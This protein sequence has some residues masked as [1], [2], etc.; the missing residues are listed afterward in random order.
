MSKEIYSLFLLMQLMH[1]LSAT[2]LPLELYE[3]TRTSRAAT[4]LAATATTSKTINAATSDSE[5]TDH[6]AGIPEILILSANPESGL[7]KHAQHHRSIAAEAA[8]QRRRSPNH[9]NKKK[10]SNSRQHRRVRQMSMETSMRKNV[11]PKIL[12]Q[13]GVSD[14]IQSN[15]LYSDRRGS[16]QNDI[17]THYQLHLYVGHF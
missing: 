8:E 6:L 9:N 1:L 10:G 15:V 13:V 2:R 11:S 12:Y 14:P 4:P 3:V 16:D 7:M 17:R 5:T